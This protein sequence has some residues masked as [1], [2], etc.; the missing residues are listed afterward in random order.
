MSLTPEL[1]TAICAGV[2]LLI[3]FTGSIIGAVVFIFRKIDRLRDQI[4]TDVDAKHSENNKRIGA[5]ENVIHHKNFG[6]RRR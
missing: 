1:F 2:T 6:A 4:L 5:L 3:Y